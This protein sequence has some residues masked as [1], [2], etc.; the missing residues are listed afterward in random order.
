MK[1]K[2]T[3]KLVAREDDR[4]FGWRQTRTTISKVL[5]RARGANAGR[6]N[7]KPWSSPETM[8]TLVALVSI[9]GRGRE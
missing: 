5:V 7:Q 2:I 8:R 4:K 3:K 6:S 9:E 1:K